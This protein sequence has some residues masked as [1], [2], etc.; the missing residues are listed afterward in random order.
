MK[1]T[2]IKTNKEKTTPSLNKKKQIF[3]F[4]RN[5]ILLFSFVLTLMMFS[6][7]KDGEVGPQGEKGIPGNANV[8]SMNF[9]LD[10]TM[11]SVVGTV[12]YSDVVVPILTQSIF[13]KGSINVY[14]E[15]PTQTGIWYNLPYSILIDSTSSNIST[16]GFSFWQGKVR[17]NKVDSQLPTKP[18]QLLKFRVSV[19]DGLSN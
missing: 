13:E 6:C 17:I 1:F 18:K 14:M 15:S 5:A 12:H 10:S 19:V 11:W 3:S 4:H 7:S 16:F 9:N 2:L 8:K